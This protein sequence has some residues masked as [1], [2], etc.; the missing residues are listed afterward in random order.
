V[1]DGKALVL[2]ESS[3][4]EGIPVVSE[5]VGAPTLIHQAAVGES[6]TV[7]EV[8]LYAVN[9]SAAIAKLTVLI[10]GVIDDVRDLTPDTGK[11]FILPGQR[12]K[13]GAKV[14]AHVE[15]GQASS[16]NINGW[17]NKLQNL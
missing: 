14:E 2:S 4:G 17:I 5:S 11:A 1:T 9:I 16:I 6:N 8:W 3:K 12:I 15:I 10:D 13:N 7:E